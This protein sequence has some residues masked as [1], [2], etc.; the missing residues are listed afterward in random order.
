MQVINFA[1]EE[2]VGPDLGRHHRRGGLVKS[3]LFIQDDFL[4]VVAMVRVKSIR[5]FVPSSLPASTPRR[6]L[7]L[8]VRDFVFAVV[9]FGGEAVF[10]VEDELG[11][12]LLVWSVRSN[13]V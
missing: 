13:V 12:L 6:M 1:S 8:V 2:R 9:V 7:P 3:G 10:E 11:M 4:S 5:L